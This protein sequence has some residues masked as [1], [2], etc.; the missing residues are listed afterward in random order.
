MD[1]RSFD[2]FKEIAIGHIKREEAILGANKYF[3]L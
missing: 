1:R 3:K 2:S